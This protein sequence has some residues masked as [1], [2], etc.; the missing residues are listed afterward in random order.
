MQEPWHPGA[1]ATNGDWPVPA[2]LLP[3][4]TITSWLA[5]CALDQGC[6]PS[7]LTG[8]LWPAWRIWTTDAD[9]GIPA[10][11]RGDLERATGMAG[12]AIE[13]AALVPIGTRI[14]GDHPKDQAAWPWI[15]T[16]GTRGGPTSGRQYCPKC[17]GEDATPHYRLRWRMAW[18]HR[19]RSS[20]LEF[21]R[22]AAGPAR[23]LPNAAREAAAHNAPNIAIRSNRPSA[24]GRLIHLPPAADQAAGLVERTRRVL[25]AALRPRVRGPSARRR[26]NRSFSIPRFA[27][28]R[29]RRRSRVYVASTN[30]SSTSRAVA[31]SR[32][33]SRNFCRRGNFSTVGTSHS[34]KRYV[35][36][37]AGPVRRA[38]CPLPADDAITE[39]AGG[40][41][42]QTPER[43]K[44]L[45]IKDLIQRPQNAKTLVDEP[46]AGGA[47]EARAR[48]EVSGADEP[49]AAAKHT[50]D[51][52]L[53][54][55]VRC[56][57]PQVP[58]HVRQAR[59]V[60]AVRT[61]R[62]RSIRPCPQP[63]PVTPGL[64]PGS[65]PA[66][67]PPR[68]APDTTMPVV[69]LSH[70]T[71]ARA[72]SQLTH[73]TGWRSVC[74]K[75]GSRQESPPPNVL[76][77]PPAPPPVADA[78]ARYSPTVHLVAAHRQVAPG[79]H[80]HLR[81][82][83]A[84]PEHLPGAAH[85][86]AAGRRAQG[87]RPGTGR[88]ASRRPPASRPRSR[89]GPPLRAGRPANAAPPGA[90]APA[91]ETP[92]SGTATDMPRTPQGSCCWRSTARTQFQPANSPPTAAA[93]PGPSQAQTARPRPRPDR[94]H[95]QTAVLR[96]TLR[97]D[98]PSIAHRV[99]T[100]IA[101]SPL[102]SEDRTA[103][104][105]RRGRTPRPS[106]PAGSD[107]APPGPGSTPPR[108]PGCCSPT[109]ARCSPNR[110][111]ANGTR[112]AP[113]AGRP[114]RTRTRTLRPSP[115]P[116]SRRPD[117]PH[118]PRTDRTSTPP[119]SP[120]RT[121]R[122][123]AP[124]PRRP[125]RSPRPSPTDRP[126]AR[127]WPAPPRAP[128]PPNPAPC[129]GT[130][131]ATA[132]PTLLTS[133]R[134]SPLPEHVFPGAAKLQTNRTGDSA[135]HRSCES[136]ADAVTARYPETAAAAAAIPRGRTDTG[137]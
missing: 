71:Y 112:P 37:N 55:A 111:P 31:C 109:P 114:R 88:P 21:A 44:E 94:P 56:P 9:R 72:S 18:P 86:I 89:A 24:R 51:A 42:P 123:R 115:P 62:A 54:I 107:A 117:R 58:N 130:R 81:A 35:D 1:Q 16:L 11:R 60:R 105:P 79:Q 27:A 47:P 120:G 67:I 83:G 68:S 76:H 48:P 78:N 110:H 85:R 118:T 73:V 100:A 121:R 74:G 134:P 64:R 106:D 5:R 93:P 129:S 49:G 136:E 41:R 32:S 96:P 36:S 12:E 113:P 7:V 137:R 75:P 126:G 119:S 108:L 70:D 20:R 4:E 2:D 99:T 23:R 59:R 6:A 53:F 13:A 8:S 90:L 34:T 127:R 80:H 95:R 87:W 29:C 101:V 69:R 135:G 92:R 26:R 77:P 98:T 122:A 15:S 28:A 17:L 46:V 38:P 103:R 116:C 39:A 52:I 25:V 3:D 14:V 97:L 30:R 45:M 124:A 19:W 33:P 22:N 43:C 102:A 50:T 84:V 65:R 125:S 57:L 82:L 133:S 104:P 40:S 132:P 91:P 61:D 63:Q 66:P 10:D 131:T 128:A